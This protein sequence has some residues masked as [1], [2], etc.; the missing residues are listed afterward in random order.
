MKKKTLL[1]LP[2]FVLM[3]SACKLPSRFFPNSS[4]NNKPS[5]EVTSNSGNSQGGNES[6]GGGS[7]SENPSSE[8]SQTADVNYG[9]ESNPLSI[10]DVLTEVAKLN[11]ESKAYSPSFFF[12]E[13]KLKTAMEKKTYDNKTSYSFTLTDDSKDMNVSSGQLEEGKTEADYAIADLITLRAY[14]RAD[15]SKPNGY[16]F[17][18]NNTEAAESGKESPQV[19]SSKKGEIPD[20]TGITI[21]PAGQTEVKQG[22][23]RQ[24]T[25]ELAPT[26]AEGDVVWVISPVD[27]KVTIDKDGLVTVEEDAVPAT[28]YTVTGTVKGTQLSDSATIKV[29]QG[30][31]EEKFVSSELGVENGVAVGPIMMGPITV[32]FDKGTNGN[33]P[34]YYTTG[35]AIRCYGGNTIAV[36]SAKTIIGVDFEFGKDDGSNAINADV[37]TFVEPSWTGES[38]SIVFTIDGTTGNRRVASMTVTY[39]DSTGPAPTPVAPTAIAIEGGNFNLAAEGSKQLTATLT[40]SNAEGEIEWVISPTDGKVTVSQTGLVTATNEAVADDV[41]TISAKVV[42]SDPLLA[43]QVQCTI[44]AITPLESV[45]KYTFTNTKNTEK[46]T[47]TSKILGWFTK[48]SGSNIVTSVSNPD[49]VYPGAEGSV[50]GSWSTNNALKIGKASGAGTLTLGLSQNVKKV[51]IKGI[52]WKDSLVVTINTVE[53]EDFQSVTAIKSTIDAGTVATGEFL[54]A[55]ESNSIQISTNNT[56][57]IITEIEFFA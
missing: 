2:V 26:G 14:V 17:S 38:S 5:S 37:G 33:A 25:A 53:S 45:A 11:L 9:T 51:V 35:T 55:T 31:K 42:G 1:L 34:K 54:L 6:Q 3:L 40:P 15:S 56:A 4:S 36:T 30:G 49:F 13:A 39:V 29:V 12:T 21:S 22:G 10:S 27:T 48:A 23:T 52:A 41:Y 7:E 57:I 28:I 16:Y 8:S 20:P 32:T 43:A 47:D 19:L 50:G 44:V 46:V 18:Y 24:F